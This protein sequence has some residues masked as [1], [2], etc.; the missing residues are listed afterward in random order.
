MVRTYFEYMTS[1]YPKDS[2]HGMLLVNLTGPAAGLP[3]TCDSGRKLLR[4]ASER[5]GLGLVRP[6][7]LRHDF[8]SGVLHASGGNSLIA[9]DAGGWASAKTVEEIYGHTDMDDPVL[10]RALSAVW[11]ETP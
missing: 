1:E 6:H 9:R 8:G 4:R 11:G 5:L 3:W 10:A 7:Q 2:V